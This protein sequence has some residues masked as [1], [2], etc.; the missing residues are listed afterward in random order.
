MEVD[1]FVEP[2]GHVVHHFFG[3]YVGLTIYLLD[4]REVDVV[5]GYT[6]STSN[7][8]IDVTPFSSNLLAELF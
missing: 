5:F 7:V 8:E 1:P 2:G 6:Y 3:E 4:V